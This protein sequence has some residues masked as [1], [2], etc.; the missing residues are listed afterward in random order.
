MDR[1]FDTLVLRTFVAAAECGEFAHASRVVGRS[2]GAVSMQIQK[3]ERVVD[4][5]LFLRRKAGVSLTDAGR[6]FL[7]HAKNILDAKDHA[8][9]EMA[10]FNVQ[11]DVRVGIPQDFA[12]TFLPGILG[13]FTR[14]HPSV[15]LTAHVD[16][17]VDLGE[18]VR[19]GHLDLALTFG[20]HTAAEGQVLAEVPAVWIGPKDYRVSVEKRVPLVAFTAPCIF[21]EI[22][23][24]SLTSCG[25]GHLVSMNST[26]LQGLWT[27]VNAGLGI[28]VRTPIQLPPHL[29]VLG[30]EAGLPPLPSV[31][32]RLHH[33]EHT[34]SE[35]MVRLKN[36]L[37]EEI[38]A[39]LPM[40]LMQ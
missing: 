30:A 15:R 31:K 33:A 5:T 22:A 7:P 25:L 20:L 40:N 1:N 2:Q 26:S 8:L 6:R 32:I 36:I 23:Q 10:G 4:Q 34:A 11:G 18:A 16:R 28:A 37:K 17:N 29:T 14:S 21:R 27:G 9:R 12:E 24:N 19:R 13:A 35:A 39:H 3:L 38:A